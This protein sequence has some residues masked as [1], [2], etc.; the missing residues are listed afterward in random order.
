[1]ERGLAGELAGPQEIP[2]I[3]LRTFAYGRDDRA[4]HAAVQ[5][6]F[7][8]H[9][10]FV[11]RGFDEWAAHRFH[12][13][14]FNPDLWFVAEEGSEVS[15][16]LMGVEEEGKMWVGMLGVRPSWRKRG[17]GEAL[18]RYA[19]VEFRRRGYQEVGLSVDAGNETGATALY[20]RVGM[21]ATRRFDV[22]EKR[23]R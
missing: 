3:R 7:A 5:E 22:Y 17:I 1:M 20:E 18:L 9:W 10:G 8:D 4:I 2:G 12:E 19:F 15:G 21:R 6:S 16:F 14:A 23:L 13:S 11:Q